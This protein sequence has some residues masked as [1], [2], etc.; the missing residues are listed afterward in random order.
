MSLSSV[1]FGAKKGKH[2]F[3]AR[4]SRRAIGCRSQKSCARKSSLDLL[5]PSRASPGRLLSPGPSLIRSR[6]G[7][8]ANRTVCLHHRPRLIRDYSHGSGLESRPSCVMY[9][10][11]F[12][13]VIRTLRL[14]LRFAQSSVVRARIISDSRPFGRLAAPYWSFALACSLCSQPLVR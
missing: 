12:A 2:L 1:L 3:M 6:S 14:L 10:R 4:R 8:C 13:R 5:L 7:C 11:F 9:R